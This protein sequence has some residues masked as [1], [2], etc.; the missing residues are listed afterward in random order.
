MKATER[1]AELERENAELK[2]HLATRNTGVRKM[3]E[4]NILLRAQVR[5]LQAVGRTSYRV[6]QLLG[7]ALARCPIG[8]PDNEAWAKAD[9]ARDALEPD[10]LKEER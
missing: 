3:T 7:A 4:R 10:D 8:H 2:E 6:H 9:E 1:I 5:R